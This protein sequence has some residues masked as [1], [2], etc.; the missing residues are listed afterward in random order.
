MVEYPI[1]C[2]KFSKVGGTIRVFYANRHNGVRIEIE[3]NCIG[4][5]METQRHAFEG[6]YQ[7][8][9]SRATAV[10]GLGLSIA[11]RIV[12]LNRGEINITS[13]PNRGTLFIVTL[14]TE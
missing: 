13:E 5:S 8:V 7:G 2:I 4:M 12:E 11:K 9:G 1:K 3:D 6:F 10:S 14:P